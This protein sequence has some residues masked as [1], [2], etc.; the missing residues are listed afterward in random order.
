MLDCDGLCDPC[1]CQFPPAR[2]PRPPS[3]AA[4][5]RGWQRDAREQLA[6]LSG[7]G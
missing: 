3:R 1:R 5:K 2:S 6:E 7:V 4:E